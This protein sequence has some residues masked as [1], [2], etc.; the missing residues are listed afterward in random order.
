MTHPLAELLTYV[1]HRDTCDKHLCGVCGEA[2]DHMHHVYG[3][4]DG[5][6]FVPQ[7]DVPCTCGLDATLQ[8]VV[9]DAGLRQI[10]KSRV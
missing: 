5:H 1:Q 2:Q 4:E 10:W 9:E 6:F 7:P 8:R 3:G